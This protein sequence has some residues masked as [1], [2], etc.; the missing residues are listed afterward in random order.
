MP[1]VFRRDGLRF[2]FYSNEG[3]PR[4]L[5]HVHVGA[6]TGRPRFGSGKRYLIADNYGFTPRELARILRIVTDEREII[7]RALHD[8]FTDGGAF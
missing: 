3:A 7:L 8:H 4:E 5:P 1:V 2:F 6:Q